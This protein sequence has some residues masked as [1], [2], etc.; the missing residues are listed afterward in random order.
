MDEERAYDQNN[1]SAAGS[2]WNEALQR[3][4]EEALGGMSVE[5]ILDGEEAAREAGSEKI[6]KGR[7]LAVHGDDVFVEM[8]GKTQGVVPA[9]QFQG[10]SLPAAGDVIEVTVEGYDKDDGL[11]LLSRKGAIKQAAWETLQKG[12]VV[13]GRVTGNNVGGLELDIN[14]ISA[15][16]PISQIE[17]THVEELS[18]YVNQRLRCQVIEIDRPRKRVVVSRRAVLEEEAAQAREQTLAT[19]AEGQV[20]KGTVKT[21]MPYGAFVDIG[22]VD[23]LLHI[24]EMSYKRIDDPRSVVHEGQQLEVMVLRVDRDSQKISLGLKQVM[25]DPWADAETKWPVNEI[26]TGRISRL[27]EF[28]AFVELE[29]GLEGLIPISE[30]SYERRIGHPSQVVQEGQVLQVRVL[31]VDT[32]RKRISLSLK[33]VGDD[34]WMGASVRWAANSIVEG[35]VKRITDFGAFVELTAGVEGLVHIS[36]LSDKRVRS[37]GDVLSEGQTVK[38]KVLSVDEEKRRISLSIKQA[39]SEVAAQQAAE[40]P[41]QRRRPKRKRP[42][43]GGLD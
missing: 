4:V 28:G 1:A 33:Q 29:E 15:F 26:V 12:Q 10:E 27:T 30:L 14:G 39:A 35:T 11:I 18:P 41:Q 42:L 32:Q 43:R 2:D 22:G 17:I 34:P 23:G 9:E 40:E 8:G 5:Q 16:M 3:E 37:V 21:I 13:E 31:S 19:L 20:V 38:A 7:V 6:R 24:G 36:E 25:P